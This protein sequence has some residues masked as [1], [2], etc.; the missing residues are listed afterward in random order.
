[1]VNNLILT[2][3]KLTPLEDT[4][5]IL[6]L[7]SSLPVKMGFCTRIQKRKPSWIIELKV[8]HSKLLYKAFCNL[9]EEW[10]SFFPALQSI[11]RHLLSLFFQFS[12][13]WCNCLLAIL[14]GCLQVTWSSTLELNSSYLPSKH[15][16]PSVGNILGNGSCSSANFYSSFMALA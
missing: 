3:L 14:F 2:L 13:P 11:C 6:F 9:V 12:F 16:L 5:P 10:K 15:A 4:F 7:I 8:I 1:M